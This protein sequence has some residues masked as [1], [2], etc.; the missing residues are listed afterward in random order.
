SA[1]QKSK[2]NQEARSVLAYS[3][4]RGRMLFT[5]NEKYE[6]A[7]LSTLLYIQSQL[8]SELSLEILARRVGFSPYHFH[9]VF[10]EVMGEPVKAYVRRLRIDRAAYRLKISQETIMPIALD[11]GFKTH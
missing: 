11:A 6:Q 8:E 10:R 3:W 7:I 4:L 2:K 9:R 1:E 5:T